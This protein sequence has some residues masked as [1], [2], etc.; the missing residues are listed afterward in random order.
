VGVGTL[1]NVRDLGLEAAGV[2]FDSTEGI[3]VDDFLRTSNPRIFAA[4]DVCAGTRFPHVESA[5]VE[6]SSPTR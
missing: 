6:S 4:G 5:A 1:P 2:A 3:A